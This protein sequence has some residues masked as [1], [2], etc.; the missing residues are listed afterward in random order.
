MAPIRRYLRITRYSV[1]EVR[2][3]LEQPSLAST[4]LLSTRSPALPRII[5]AIQPLVLPKLREENENAKRKAGAGKRRRA[6]KDTVSEDDFEV[7]IFLTESGGSHALMTKSKDF[8]EG[9]RTRLRGGERMGVASGMGGREDPVVVGDGDVLREEDED[10]EVRLE[11]IPAVGQT[12]EIGSD[13]EEETGARAGR[14]RKREEGVG[15][16]DDKKKLGLRTAYEGFNIYGRILCLVVKRK[17][18]KAKGALANGSSEMLENWVSTQVDKEGVS[19][20]D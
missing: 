14:K 19:I 6:T 9:G 2:I 10:D 16:A 4:W 11:D 8:D 1:L 7:S 5:A 15:G 20:D 3:Y 17:G 12:I 18:A 13:E